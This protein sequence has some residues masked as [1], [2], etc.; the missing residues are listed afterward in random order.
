MDSTD[1]KALVRCPH[2][3][4]LRIAHFAWALEGYPNI[5][6]RALRAFAME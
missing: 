5:L 6:A 4:D 2:I 1:F 3:G